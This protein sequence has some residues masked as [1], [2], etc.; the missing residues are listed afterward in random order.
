MSLEEVENKET[1]SWKRSNGQFAILR[2]KS[3]L[4]IK[5]LFEV[6]QKKPNNNE[7]YYVTSKT[8]WSKFDSICPG[9]I[10]KSLSLVLQ[11]DILV[12]H[13]VTFNCC[14]NDRR[15][16]HQIHCFPFVEIIANY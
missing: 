10:I 13:Q 14:Q 9:T 16:L 12:F 7:K 3:D 1:F 6:A 11:I 5:R 8:K 4:F 2:K 15:L